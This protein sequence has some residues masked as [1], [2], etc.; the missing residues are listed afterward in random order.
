MVTARLLGARTRRSSQAKDKPF[1]CPHEG[2]KSSFFHSCNL[3]AHENAKH[4]RR[5]R[6]RPRVPIGINQY[7][8]QGSVADAPG[9]VD[10]RNE[11]GSNDDDTRG[12]KL[13]E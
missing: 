5:P 6:S 2:C 3:R 13:S 7:I 9:E 12:N 10:N 11:V 1:K 8:G 4:G